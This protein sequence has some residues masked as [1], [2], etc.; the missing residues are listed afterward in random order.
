MLPNVGFK[1]Y[2]LRALFGPLSF[3]YFN[4]PEFS[5]LR[6]FLWSSRTYNVKWA[7][8]NLV[9]NII[10]CKTTH[11]N[12]HCYIPGLEEEGRQNKRLCKF[13]NQLIHC[14]SRSLETLKKMHLN[15]WEGMNRDE[16]QQIKWFK[17]PI[18]LFLFFAFPALCYM[19]F[20]M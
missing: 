7:I 12:T 10:M 1:S 17:R 14:C 4:F 8:K 16:L 13:D 3:A 6:K 15:I 18:M 2:V 11:T 5:K 9:Q 20:R 19:S